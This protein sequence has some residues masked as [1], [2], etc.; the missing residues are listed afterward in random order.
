M[1]SF[2]KLWPT[3]I[4][5]CFFFIFAVA[6][7]E[8]STALV[9][10]V[11][12]GDVLYQDMATEPW[13][14]ASLTKLMTVYVA[15]SAVREG[16]ITLDTP[17]MVSPRAATMPPSKMGFRPGTLVTLD[18]A[19]KMLMVKSPNDVAVTIAEGIS[20][21]VEAFADDM[22]VYGTR[23]GLHESHF[24]NPNGLPDER[25][26]SSARDMAIIAR[27]LLRE[28]PEEH[29]LFGIGVLAF[30]NQII[31]NHNGLLGRYPGVDGMKTGYTCSAGYN[32]VASAEHNGRRLITV[33]M[34]APSN[35]TRNEKAAALF[36][37]FFSGASTS[38]G[39]LGSL[40]ASNANAPPDLR[41]IICGGRRRAAIIEAEGEDAAQLGAGAGAGGHL[42][43]NLSRT[44]IAFDPVRV[45]IG[46]VA[47]WTGRIAQAVGT[48]SKEMTP[49]PVR[50]AAAEPPAPA[51]GAV[52]GPIESAAPAP[53][54]LLG[55]TPLAPA[56]LA[57]KHLVRS[58]PSLGLEVE[59]KRK[60][61]DRGRRVSQRTKGKGKAKLQALAAV[62][63]S[64]A[65]PP[66]KPKGKGAAQR[67]TVVFIRKS[68]PV[69]AKKPAAKLEAKKKSA[70]K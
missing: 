65:L 12:S 11:D 60:M 52:G 7:A 32:V 29:G 33:I 37:K 41:P 38:Y 66:E 56:A 25:H 27:A 69:P 62:A 31:N 48:G 46:P 35:E 44:R 22:N 53:L 42:S 26:M 54:A 8:A 55:A 68:A 28:F 2:R 24:A 13:Y 17:L 5:T 45:N 16:R 58:A 20:G 19:L 64:K 57:A 51:N 67:K 43:P 49:A 30:G 63:A 15:L 23:L 3:T 40:P 9:V 1:A 59:S 6:Q 50:T 34:G 61:H 4:A 36:D 14:P 70:S 39:G 21:S 47:G 18:N 10:D